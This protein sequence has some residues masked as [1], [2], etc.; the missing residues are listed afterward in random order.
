ALMVKDR[1]QAANDVRA[2]T[3]APLEQRLRILPE[4]AELPDGARA[5]LRRLRLCDAAYMCAA[6]VVND[7]HVIL[8]S[9]H[10][11]GEGIIQQ[12]LVR[13]AAGAWANPQEN[14]GMGDA[15][16]MPDLKTA[17]I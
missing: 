5:Q 12:E 11:A 16:T 14:D 3:A 8:L 10:Q 6:Y 15:R 4:G 7:A 17:V 9:Q 2:A 1:W 13:N